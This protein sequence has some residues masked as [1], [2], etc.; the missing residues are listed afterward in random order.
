MWES[1]LHPDDRVRVCRETREALENA[2]PLDLRYR[3]LAKDGTVRWFHDRGE[4]VPDRDGIRCIWQGI[5]MDISAQCE[6]EEAL[7]ATEARA[8]T[9]VETAYEGIWLVD[10]TGAT[11]YANARM[12]EMLGYPADEMVGRTMF[13]FMAP[14]AAFEAR[15]LFARRQRGISEMH[16]FTFRRRDG[17]ELFV[18]LSTSPFVGADGEFTGALAMATDITARRSV[19]QALRESEARFRHVVANAPGMVYQF[20]YRADGTKGYTFVSEGVRALFGVEP[21]AALEDSEALLRIVHPEDREALRLKARGV[22]LESGDFRWEGRVVLASG[23]ERLIEVAARDQRMADGSVVSDGLVVDVTERRQLEAQLRQ[24]QKME[25]VGRLAG[26]VAHDFNNLLTVIKASTTFLLEELDPAD[27]RRED[28]RHVAD[29]ADR[30]A[31]LTRQLLAFSRKQRLEPTVLHIDAVV[32]NLRPLLARL[33]GEDVE[34]QVQLAASA[35]SVMADVGQLEQVLINLAINA[36]DA[37]PDG[38]RLTIETL[39]V[40]IDERTALAYGRREQCAVLA[41]SYVMLGVSDTGT[42][43]SPEVRARIF[44]PFFTTKE[45]GK[46]TGLGLST[47]YGIVQQSGGHVWVYSE[48]GH[49]TVFKLYFPRLE[50]AATASLKRTGES[51]AGG[52]ETVLLV[53]DEES[54]RQLARRILERQGYRVLESRNGREAL[55][56]ATAFGDQIHLILTDVVMPELSGR[57]LIERLTAVRPNAAVIYMSGYADDEVLRRGMLEPGSMFIQKPFN[58][59]AL[60]RLVREALDHR[61]GPIGSATSHPGSE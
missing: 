32:E 7:R 30:A 53:E 10:A 20:V 59:S 28:A 43:M 13:D 31:G 1:R 3:V 6:A 5:M 18:L 19:E 24:S 22:A 25:A 29:A 2:T 39:E 23:E 45:V 16:E 56:Q 37:M 11:T 52:T 38:G 58:P 17:S 50:A 15:T 54:V 55:A 44:E 4:L 33:I 14:A 41:G 46:G 61:H 34:V 60:L 47:V 40:T 21:A 8:R 12:C 35:G 9:I 27:P 26:G 48:P 51:P 49:G 57:G 36:R 42:G